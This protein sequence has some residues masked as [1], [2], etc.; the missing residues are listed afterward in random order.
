VLQLVIAAS[1]LPLRTQL[2]WYSHPLWLPFALLCGPLL[3]ALV[4]PSEDLGRQRILH[5]L[6][7]FWALLGG[8]L[9]LVPLVAGG[10]RLAPLAQLAAPAGLGLLAGGF[11][12]SRPAAT[13]RQLGAGLLV[14]GWWLSLLLFFQS[15]L[16]NWEL[17]ETWSVLPVAELARAGGSVEP[18]EP[19]YLAGEA[20]Q[21][22]SLRWYAQGAIRRL[23]RGEQVPGLPPGGF[24]LIQRAGDS[25]PA[26]LV[27]RNVSCRLDGLAEPD[28]QRWRCRLP[29][30]GAG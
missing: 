2:P 16:W 1:I 3:A 27:E 25:L 15:P 20:A 12:L 30:G 23:P 29:G 21:R 9:L 10:S 19:V 6:P 26:S 11:L 18:R 17:N 13:G 14:A 8:A 5:R 28:W 24:D 7:W 22:P 4:Q